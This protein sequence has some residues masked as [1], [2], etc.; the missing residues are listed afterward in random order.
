MVA[1]VSACGL[2]GGGDG[3]AV[4]SACR[5]GAP[6][7]PPP[8]G[9]EASLTLQ[10]GSY[11]GDGRLQCVSGI[12]FQPVLVIIKAESGEWA[13]W[14]S[15]SMEVGF[16]AH[17]ASAGGNFGGAIRSLD[18]DAFS[19]G[20]S[21]VV[22]NRL[23]YHYVAFAASPD[24]KVGSYVGDGTDGRSI[25]GVGF[26][27][28]IVF[29][30]HD[31]VGAAVWSSIS[32]PEGVSSFF[33]AV[34]DRADLIRG[35]EADGFQLSADPLVNAGDGSTYHYVA[36]REAPGLLV[37]GTYTGDGSADRDITGVGF[38]PD[39]VWI[40]RSTADS[41]A[42]HRP[43]SLADDETLRFTRQPTGTNEITAL[44]PDGFQVGSGPS[45]NFDGDTYH[46]VAWKSSNGP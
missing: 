44:Q 40:K 36:F 24:T 39:Y 28:A 13:L 14:R 21:S 2:G 15:S 1:V 17:F 7:E 4:E 9:P 45:V 12:G 5:T 31:G 6:T 29:L 11:I 42:V 32:H 19:L 35:F 23:R 41:A 37:T 27:P 18:P 30:K 43:S 46:Y 10:T 25:T 34:E 16:S 33:G 26:Q 38:Q 22:N 20:Q 8:P 3:G